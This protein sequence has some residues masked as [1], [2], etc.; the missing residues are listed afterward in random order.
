MQAEAVREA[1]NRALELLIASTTRKVEVVAAL[2][3]LNRVVLFG[4]TA[5][6]VALLAF[7][8]DVLY[9]LQCRFRKSCFADEC[10]FANCISECR[11]LEKFVELQWRLVYV[12][13]NEILEIG[14]ISTA[15]LE[16]SLV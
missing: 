9:Q 8:R 11:A 2:K 7:T 1:A 10:F 13:V 4:W 5:L 14:N 3:T 15:I 16:L 12:G 6:L